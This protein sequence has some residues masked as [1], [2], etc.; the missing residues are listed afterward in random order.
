MTRVYV[1]SI[2]FGHGELGFGAWPMAKSMPE[3]EYSIDFRLSAPIA[4]DTLAMTVFASCAIA[5]H[6]R[7][8]TSAR[9][10]IHLLIIFA[11][12]Q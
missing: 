4:L 1:L 3:P 9:T 5:A 12:S 2:N 6:D 8:I 10:A 11:S 7:S